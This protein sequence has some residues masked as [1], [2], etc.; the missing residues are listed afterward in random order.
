MSN[1]EPMTDVNPKALSGRRTPALGRR[2]AGWYQRSRATLLCGLALFL[3]QQLGLAVSIAVWLPGLRDPQYA[4]KVTGLKE[5][6]ET[7]PQPLSIVM[8][9]SSRTAYGLAASGLEPPLSAAVGQPV[10]VYNFGLLGAGPVTELL[11]LRRLLEDGIRPSLLLVEVLPPLLAGQVPLHEVEERRLPACSLRSDEL[12]LVE[13][14]SGS[15]RSRLRET[16]CRSCLLPW[17]YHRFALVSKIMP[18]LLHHTSRRNGFDGADESG[19]VPIH[20]PPE[21]RD[22]A[23][24]RAHR[25]YAH[26]LNG[27]RLGGPAVK[28]LKELL[29][30]CRAEHVPVTL[31]MMPEGPAFRSWYPPSAWSQIEAHLNDLHQR[32]NVPVINARDWLPEE[33][34]WDSHHLLPGAATRFSERLSR[35]VLPLLRNL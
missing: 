14:Y 5:R 18:V 34:F 16:W 13:S 8:L 1:R 7:S 2:R 33:D 23:L 32:Y 22:Q 19:W 12:T 26:Y 28:G 24:A 4:H 31:V 6:M 21:L 20:A 9:G 25:E 15:R 27:F 10:V 35:E 3:L 29:D 17:Y 11:T 30:L